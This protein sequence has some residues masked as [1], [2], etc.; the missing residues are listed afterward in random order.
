MNKKEKERIKKEFEE[1]HKDTIIYV[2]DNM[3]GIPIDEYIEQESW[4]RKNPE[5]GNIH[6]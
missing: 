2:F 6:T 4:R 1:K 5:D 3:V